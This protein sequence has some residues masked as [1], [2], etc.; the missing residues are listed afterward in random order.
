MLFKMSEF[1][2]FTTNGLNFSWN[3]EHA[4]EHNSLLKNGVFPSVLDI[5]IFK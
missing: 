5:I 1:H 3:S 4:Q 2:S